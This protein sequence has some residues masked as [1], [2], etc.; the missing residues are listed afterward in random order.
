MKLLIFGATGAVGK[1]TARKAIEHGHEVTLHVRDKSRVPEDIS[2]SDKVTV[3]LL[4]L[5]FSRQNM[6]GYLLIPFKA[7]FEGSLSDEPSLSAAIKGQDAILSSIGPKNIFGDYG[8]QFTDGYRLIIKLMHEHGVRRIIAMS[9]ISAYDERD[10]F[11]FMR[12]AAYW[13]VHLLGRR[14]QKEI[15]GIGDV[16]KK[17]G[18]GLDWTLYRVGVLGDSKEDG[19]VAQAGWV[20]D[21]KST[22]YLERRDWANWMIQEVEREEPMWVREMPVISSPYSAAL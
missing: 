2:S 4:L 9:T 16:F 5:P 12:S 20:G 8:R 14:A 18:E 7:I 1:L 21:G 22:I 17:D 11:T 10:R 15:L 6:L 3:G 19:R 13:T